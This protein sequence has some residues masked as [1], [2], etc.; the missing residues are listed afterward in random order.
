VA[1]VLAK[2]TG[3]NTTR[4]TGEMH[5]MGTGK[6]RISLA[7]MPA[8][9]RGSERVIARAAEPELET[10]QVEAL[11]LVTGQ[12]LVAEALQAEAELGTAPVE[13]LELVIVRAVVLELGTAPVVA[14]LGTAPVVA[15]LEHDPVAVE[16]VRDHPRAQLAAARKTKSVIV[17]H[18][19][20]LPLLAAVEDLAAAVA[21][22]TREP[23]VTAAVV[24]WVV[25]VTAAAEAG[26]AVAVE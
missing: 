24:V 12:A 4:N 18:R 1:L 6:R 22:T 15:E 25:A 3:G 11:G 20:G 14:E 2:E 19:R 9:N 26:I 17:A 13:A 10:V 8:S 21:E 7:P 16:P 23:A 5:P